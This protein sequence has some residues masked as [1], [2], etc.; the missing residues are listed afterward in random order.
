VEPGSRP[1][2]APGGAWLEIVVPARNEAARLPAGLARLCEK[3]AALP[4]AVE[5]VVVDSASTD[6][7]A[8]VVRQ[9]PAGPVPVRLIRCDRPGKGTAVRAGLLATR[10]PFVGYCDADMAT[11]LA[12]LDA[13]IA[14]LQAGRTMVIG[15][16]SHPDSDVEDRHSWLRRKGAYVFRWLA[17]LLTGGVLDSQ[18]GFK[19]FSGPLA[20]AAAAPMVATGFAFDIEFIARCRKQGAEPL[21]IPVRWHDV[22][23]STFSMRR[24]ALGAFAEIGLIW[25][26]LHLPAAAF[27]WRRAGQRGRGS[28]AAARS[29]VAGQRIAVVNWRDPW[30]P[31][32]GGAER[33]AWEMALG[34]ARRGAAIRFITARGAGQAARDEHAGIDIVR[35]GGRWTV[36]PRVLAWLAV[37]RRS[38]DAVLD[39]QNGIPFFTPLVLPRRVQVLCVVH[40]VHD[41]QFGVHFPAAVAAVG[42]WLEGPTARWCYRRHASVAVSEST[43]AAMR[44]RL[45]WTGPIHIIPNGLPADAARGPER[46]TDAE[47]GNGAAG[48]RLTCVGR[49]VAHKR[50]E[51]VLDV[52]ERLA[53]DGVTIHVIGSGP[54]YRALAEQVS[55]RG[56]GEIVRLHGYLPEDAKRDLVA[57]S[58]LHLNTSQGEGWGLCVLEAAA[59][60]VPTVAY[61]VDGLRD[62]VRDGETGWLVRSDELIE[63]V[64]ERAIKEL[65]DPKRRAEIAAACRAWAARFDWDASAGWLADLIAGPGGPGARAPG[66]RAPGDAVVA[67]AAPGGDG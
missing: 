3:A 49:L 22:A 1:C 35:M 44:A 8:D 64:V 19:F 31:D 23:G 9:W 58:D 27:G 63:D 65:A 57:R 56:L 26:A 60:G 21:E 13:A 46:R 52:G 16:R 5:I 18:C 25:V 10:A 12:A 59:L 50:T 28:S 29:A 43:A 42:R 34:L 14:Y 40:H 54:G 33:Y 62:A 6:G 11:D 17:R 53:D 67:A 15:S 51:R 24:H 48:P 66:V 37:R 47:S 41:A 38:F 20:R 30:H 61:D 7:T 45:A 36:Y 2:G 32:N 55:G 4:I 39:C